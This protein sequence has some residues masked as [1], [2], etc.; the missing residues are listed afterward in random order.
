MVEVGEVKLLLP[1]I[2]DFIVGTPKHVAITKDAPATPDI[3]GKNIDEVRDYI[4][5][6]KW[7]LYLLSDRYRLYF[8]RIREG[9]CVRH[10]DLR[11][12]L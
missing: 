7:K 2:F 9:H 11:G 5:E 1:I 10:R 8:G 6:N 12:G 4:E 3:N